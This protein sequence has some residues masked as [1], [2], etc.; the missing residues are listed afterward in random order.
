MTIYVDKS[1]VDLNTDVTE[2]GDEDN[3]FTYNASGTISGLPCVDS[4]WHR[5]IMWNA[6]L[7]TLGVIL[8]QADSF[9]LRFNFTTPV[10]Y[11]RTGVNPFV[12]F[13][14]FDNAR[15]TDGHDSVIAQIDEV[16]DDTWGIVYEEDATFHGDWNA[17]FGKPT[18]STAY[19]YTV[20]HDAAT[21]TLTFKLYLSAGDALQDTR[22][23]VTTGWLWSC[24]MVGI[25]ATYNATGGVYDNP[26]EVTHIKANSGTTE[27]FAGGTPAKK[28]MAWL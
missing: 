25:S 22:T 8:T 14:I 1:G 3:S 10:N 6:W 21:D 15:V 11:N 26:W 20:I 18:L 5:E 7:Y 27:E 2:K 9:F 23:L 19:Y 12:N 28:V 4:K 13:G 16:F 17:A 24:D